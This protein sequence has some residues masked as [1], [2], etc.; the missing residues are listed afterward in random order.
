MGK[1]GRIIAIG[2]GKGGTGKTTTAINLAAVLSRSE[3]VILVDGSFN[4]PHISIF[5]GSP[6]LPVTLHDVLEGKNLIE[7]SIYRHSS[8]IRVVPG[9]I[10]S[11]IMSAEHLK[12]FREVVSRLSDKYS[13]V[14]ID[15]HSGFGRE[16]ETTIGSAGEVILVVEPDLV[17]LSDAI[18]TRKLIEKHGK[19]LGG[20][21]INKNS[22]DYSE[23]L[24]ADAERLLG[25][26]LLGVVPFDSA[27]IA[28]K[29]MKHPVVHSHPSSRAAAAFYRIADE[30]RGSKGRMEEEE[31]RG[32]YLINKLRG[33]K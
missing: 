33:L 11:R 5:L 7:E 23:V 28:S 30:I 4:S 12:R 20:F 8:G 14:I 32:A 16:V 10:S 3:Q 13:F 19:K 18:K 1:R 21:I 26:R 2:S 15:C 22:A 29:K 9:D 24:P 27:V 25:M 31:D 6:R 17:S